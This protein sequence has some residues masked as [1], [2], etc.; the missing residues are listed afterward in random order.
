MYSNKSPNTNKEREL[1]V[2]Q[3][4]LR[5]NSLESAYPCYYM[6]QLQR[7][8]R[9]CGSGHSSTL[10]TSYKNKDPS[11]RMTMSHLELTSTSGG[12]ER[13]CARYDM[14]QSQ[15]PLH[16]NTYYDDSQRNGLQ[17]VTHRS[18]STRESENHRSRKPFLSPSVERNQSS[19]NNDWPSSPVLDDNTSNS[20]DRR[21]DSNDLYPP[22]LP[23]RTSSLHWKNSLTTEIRGGQQRK[24]SSRASDHDSKESLD[25]CSQQLGKELNTSNPSAFSVFNHRSRIDVSTRRCYVNA[26]QFAQ[27]QPYP[28]AMTCAPS[29]ENREFVAAIIQIENPEFRR[30][31]EEQLSNNNPTTSE[32]HKNDTPVRLHREGATSEVDI[33]KSTDAMKYESV[34]TKP[35][36]AQTLPTP[37]TFTPELFRKVPISP[38][39]DLLK[40]NIPVSHASRLL[41]RMSDKL[42]DGRLADVILLAQREHIASGQNVSDN[43]VENRPKKRLSIKRIP[44]HRVILAAASDYFAA[45]FGNELKEASEAEVWIRDVEP[46]ALE[47]LVDYIYS[48]M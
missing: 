38:S 30:D 23:T 15:V 4:E 33:S 24:I 6:H 2:S 1:R 22:A 16:Y 10:C 7:C 21:H 8:P 14:T 29:T 28:A 46:D 18:S 39:C 31:T 25:N 48:G 3:D 35:D 5:S 32:Q 17:V 26:K 44:A 42:R 47:T 45:M 11:S 43:V 41:G 19:N 34:L 13:H 12:H 40:S 9:K 27:F 36:A 37:S 20:C